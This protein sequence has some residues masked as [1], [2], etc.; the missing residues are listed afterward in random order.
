MQPVSCSNRWASS[1][2]IWPPEPQTPISKLQLR[3]DTYNTR[4]NVI[5]CC[6]CLSVWMMIRRC[7][8]LFH[9]IIPFGGNCSPSNHNS[10]S[11]HC[12]CF[13][14]YSLFCDLSP[15]VITK[16]NFSNISKV[17]ITTRLHFWKKQSKR[18]AKCQTFTTFY[19]VI[20]CV[21]GSINL[22]RTFASASANF[23]ELGWGFFSQ[24]QNHFLQSH[25]QPLSGD[26]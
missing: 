21:Q 1:T 12:T 10:I 23:Y 4:L 14:I 13:F 9:S 6:V 11:P 26:C 22:P 19:W 8:R 3:Y 7:K 16:N 15:I 2:C 24:Y 17:A 18:S 5:D 25:N 20:L